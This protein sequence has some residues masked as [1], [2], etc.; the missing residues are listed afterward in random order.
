MLRAPANP[1]PKTEPRCRWA[2]KKET[3]TWGPTELIWSK[4]ETTSS[5]G[6]EAIAEALWMLLILVAHNFFQSTCEPQSLGSIP[7]QGKVARWSPHKLLTRRLPSC[8]DALAALPDLKA[9]SSKFAWCRRP[10]KQRKLIKYLR[11]RMCRKSCMS[12]TPAAKQP[13][14]GGEHG[15]SAIGCRSD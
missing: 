1:R 11:P 3:A 2:L 8:E 9:S 10:Q 15:E 12:W 14:A 4:S 7:T 13:H 6:F 5:G